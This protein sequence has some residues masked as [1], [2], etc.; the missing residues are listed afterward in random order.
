MIVLLSLLALGASAA[1]A[2][3]ECPGGMT[4]VDAFT[5][6]NN[7]P[8]I[9]CEDLEIPGRYAMGIFTSVCG[10]GKKNGVFF[11]GGCVCVC[12]C[13][14]V[15]GIIPVRLPSVC[16]PLCSEPQGIA[17]AADALPTQPRQRTE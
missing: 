14:S 9:A 15:C 1:A 3:A 16:C 10:I 17:A 12:L 4:Q 7:M 6:S 5:A 13:V 2:P 11:F 8:Y